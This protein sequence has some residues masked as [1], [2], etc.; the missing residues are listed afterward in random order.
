M[1]AQFHYGRQLAALLN[2]ARIVAACAS[3]TQ[4]IAEA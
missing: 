4:N 3:V 2:A 1:S